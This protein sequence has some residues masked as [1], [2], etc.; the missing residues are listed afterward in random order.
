[1]NVDF[2]IYSA[3][4]GDVLRKGNCPQEVV[5]LQ[6][7][8]DEA[9][10][11]VACPYD[12]AWYD[13]T[14]V[15]ESVDPTVTL[16]KTSVTADGQDSATLSPL[17]A[18]AVVTVQGVDQHASGSSFSYTT[19]TVGT[20][21]VVL[22]APHFKPARFQ[23]QGVGTL[24]AQKTNAQNQI[25]Q[26]AG[27]ARS[28]YITI[29]PGQEATYL[30]KFLDAQTYLQATNPDLT[31]YPYVAAESA[32]SGTDPGTAA[33]SIMTQAKLWA[34]KGAQIEQARLSGKYQINTAGDTSS[35][36]TLLAQTLSALNAL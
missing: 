20:A 11:Q 15:Q 27:T 14:T 34:K 17:P 33:Q 25:D 19:T 30:S 18:N 35:V 16:S 21:V 31:N 36:A 32:A 5:N 3:I 9:V 1:M 26:V 22:T 13:G 23:I 24:P 12:H 10:A 7:Q 2:I 4:T 29:A 6:I 28:R 8:Q